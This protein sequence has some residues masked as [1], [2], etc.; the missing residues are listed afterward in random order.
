[1][2]VNDRGFRVPSSMEAGVVTVVPIGGRTMKRKF[3]AGIS[4][5]IVHPPIGRTVTT[6]ASE[7]GVSASESRGQTLRGR[8]A[9]G[10]AGDAK[11]V[12]VNARPLA[13]RTARAARAH[14]AG[15]GPGPRAVP[16]PSRLSDST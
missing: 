7:L 5:E 8:V 11:R 3:A 12:A 1:M 6:P 10:P 2:R 16:H 13:R 14:I 9:G 4:S 15:G